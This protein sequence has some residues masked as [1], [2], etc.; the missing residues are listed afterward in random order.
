MPPLQVKGVM[1]HC[2]GRH[3]HLRINLEPTQATSDVAS[4]CAHKNQHVNK[5]IFETST[6]KQLA[7]EHTTMEIRR[8]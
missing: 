4:S 7:P 8:V 2:G 6:A 5:V 3:R 1:K